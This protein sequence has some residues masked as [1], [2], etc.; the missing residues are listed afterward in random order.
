MDVR[1]DLDEYTQTMQ[2]QKR[3]LQDAKKKQ[4][5]RPRDRKGRDIMLF[6]FMMATMSNTRAGSE[7]TRMIHSSF[8]PPAYPPCTTSLDALKPIAIE[9]LRLE[10]HHR[11][12]Y[13][14]LRAIT[15]PNRMTAILVLVEDEH[16]DVTMLQMYQQEDE[17]S[18]PASTVVDKGSI[19]LI[20][21]PFFKVTASGDYSLRVD[22]LSDIIFLGN[23]DSRIP[24]S[25][26]RRLFELGRSADS[27]KLEGNAFVGKGEYWRAIEKYS[28]ALA[29]SATPDEIKVIKRN[30]SLAYLKTR[31][32]DAA[33]SDTGFPDFGVEASEKALFRAAEALY[34]LTRYEECCN[35]LEKLCS[36]FPNN[37]QA[38]AAHTRA[39]YR[40][41]ESSTGEFDF[42][43]LQA[44][45]RKR[46]PPHLD[47]GTYIGPVTVRKAKGKGRGLFTT[48]SMKAGDL[49][50]C[51]KAFCHAHVDD[52]GK[53]NA[54]VTLLMNVET[55]KAFMGGQ[56][57]LIQL[58]TQKLYKNPSMAAAFTELHHGD[59]KAVNKMFVDGQP[60]V[61]SFLVERIMALNVFGCPV[62][63]LESH[64]D[65]ISKKAL[66]EDATFDSCGIWIKA[67]Y[68]NHS[69]LG[70]VRRS[71]I[72]DMMI[73]RACKD[74]EAGTELAFPYAVRG[75]DFS[76]KVEQKFKNW[77][78]ICRCALCEDI[79]A[80][81]PSEVA[82]RRSLLG[83]LD[84]LCKPGL[85]A[86]N[87]PIK[88]E[89]LIMALNETYKSPAEEV[90]RLLLWDPHLFL[91]RVY[92][93]ERDFTKVLE[94][95]GKT[96][97]TLGFIVTGLD[98]TPAALVITKWGHT[99]DHMVEIFLHGRSAFEQL[100]IWEKSKQAEQYAKVAYRILVGEEASFK[101][102]M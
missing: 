2:R 9:D 10:T 88:F 96:L 42:K 41:C 54:Q 74:L 58:I 52:S 20:K 66:K 24:P 23:D 101:S 17:A 26:R 44:E 45:A 100:G 32:Y 62:T 86:H 67:S 37:E 77:G 90:P 25:W 14:I 1:K 6:E 7:D 11:G 21:E 94:W 102:D 72:G 4:G 56:A 36:L 83:Q 95:V 18:R 65:V 12:C 92:M 87:F 22:H 28:N 97:Q 78:F 31:Q 64:K 13:L 73:V 99:V 27:L 16:G 34:H 75:D 15:P 98:R 68:I 63:S 29:H 60:V 49:V 61:D 70:N 93:D 46:I 50:L 85:K 39:R 38:V 82:K 48:K 19:L 51:E 47:H 33:L 81:K 40:F 80:T 91:T 8:V 5:Q 35:V 3:F 79:K 89:R 69:C 84:R 30:R 57:H 71:F 43:L 76:L 59:Y 53:S 55:E